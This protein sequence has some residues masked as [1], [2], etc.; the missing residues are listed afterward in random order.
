MSSATPL[1]ASELNALLAKH[2]ADPNFVILDVRTAEE[3]ADG[4]LP[5]AINIDKLQDDFADKVDALDRDKTYLLICRS[6]RRAKAAAQI[7]LASS[8]NRLLILE[9]QGR[10]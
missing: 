4:H 7:M 10:G 3:Y 8:F 9:N 1:P 5:G 6:G 2:A